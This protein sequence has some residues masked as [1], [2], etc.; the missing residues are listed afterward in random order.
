M[1]EGTPFR[2]VIDIADRLNV[3]QIVLGVRSVATLTV[4]PGSTSQNVIK[5]AKQPV[6]LIK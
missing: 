5:L 6:T 1:R 2:E 3:S 4:F